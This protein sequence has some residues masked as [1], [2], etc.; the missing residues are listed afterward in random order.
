[1]IPAAVM[2]QIHAG[3][4]NRDYTR[5]QKV[6]GGFSL[7]IPGLG[8]LFVSDAGRRFLVFTGDDGATARVPIR[9]VVG[10]ATVGPEPYMSYR[11]QL[12]DGVFLIVTDRP[13][14]R[15]GRTE[16]TPGKE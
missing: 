14:E 5:W 8:S 9:R 7:D 4:D 12:A 3:L 1:M 15:P 16:G 6:I 2:R 11:F 10:T 13:P